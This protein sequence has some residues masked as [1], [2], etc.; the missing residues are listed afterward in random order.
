MIINERIY[1]PSGKVWACFQDDCNFVVRTGSEVLY[2]AN[3]YGKG[4]KTAILR[5]NG[6]LSMSDK[7][8]KQQWTSGRRW[9]RN[10]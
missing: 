8:Q 9:R 3:T 5:A 4:I 6:E 10:P 2:T 7:D 1:S